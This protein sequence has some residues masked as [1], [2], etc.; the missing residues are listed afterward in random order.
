V[1]CPNTSS[2]EAAATLAMAA[3][4]SSSARSPLMPHPRRPVAEW[5]AYLRP[6][7]RQAATA[8]GTPQRGIPSDGI[9]GMLAQTSD[10][11]ANIPE[12][13]DFPAS[14]ERYAFVSDAALAG[15]RGFQ[16]RRTS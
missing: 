15:L 2:T 14:R 4:S 13:R 16:E 3:T 11:F 10:V 5:R 1:A 7:T 6:P 9:A 12:S 8:V